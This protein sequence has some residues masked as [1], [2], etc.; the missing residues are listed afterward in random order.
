MIVSEAEIYFISM[1]DEDSCSLVQ[2]WRHPAPLIS[3]TEVKFAEAV[4]NWESI[5]EI[6]LSYC[7]SIFVA[8]P[9]AAKA[10]EL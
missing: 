1:A 5:T 8:S 2:A 6:E 9:S 7:R 4:T 10:A 3:W